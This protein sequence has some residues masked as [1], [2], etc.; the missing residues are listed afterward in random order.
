MDDTEDLF[1]IAFEEFSKRG[2]LP[3]LAAEL[4]KRDLIGGFITLGPPR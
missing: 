4:L 3:V 1:A 2:L